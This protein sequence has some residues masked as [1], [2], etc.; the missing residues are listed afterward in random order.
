[1]ATP[2]NIEKLTQEPTGMKQ[3]PAVKGVKMVDYLKPLAEKVG[4]TGWPY[5]TIPPIPWGTGGDDPSLGQIKRLTEL[6]LMG[7]LGLEEATDKMEEAKIK[8]M[9]ERIKKNPEWDL[10]R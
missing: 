1:M 8:A 7:K 6:Y 2:E 4:E 9:E 3:I 5:F 10:S